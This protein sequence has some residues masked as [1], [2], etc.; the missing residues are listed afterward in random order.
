VQVALLRKYNTFSKDLANIY[1]RDLDTVCTA[2]VA[3]A[4]PEM[5]LVRMLRGLSQLV[6]HKCD[7][8]YRVHLWQAPRQRLWKEVGKLVLNTWV[9]TYFS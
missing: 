4:S 5:W 6:T 1:W 9:L 8:Q 2:R 3:P 7:Q